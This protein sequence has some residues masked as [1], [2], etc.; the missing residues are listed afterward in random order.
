MRETL[1]VGDLVHARV[2]DPFTYQ[3][4]EALG[5]VISINSNVWHGPATSTSER[6]AAWE[7]D[8]MVD[9][10]IHNIIVRSRDIYQPTP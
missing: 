7:C 9:N 2:N 10:K 4:R 5:I 6:P 3:P 8:V 1:Q